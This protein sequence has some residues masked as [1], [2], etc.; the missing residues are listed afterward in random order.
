[1]KTITQKM[2]VYQFGQSPSAS[3]PA[4]KNSGDEE[5]WKILILNQDQELVCVEVQERGFIPAKSFLKEGSYIHFENLTYSKS[6]LLKKR[7]T[8]IQVFNTP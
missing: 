4:T 3:A 2:M 8:A 1:M 5:V 6:V 7:D